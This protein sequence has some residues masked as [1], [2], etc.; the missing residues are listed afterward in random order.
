MLGDRP[1]G[2]SVSSGGRGSVPSAPTCP[3]I[4]LFLLRPADDR[5][6]H[7]ELWIEILQWL[8]TQSGDFNGVG[9]LFSL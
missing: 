9:D 3:T 6:Q 5:T 2:L 4:G 1:T 8:K 7:N